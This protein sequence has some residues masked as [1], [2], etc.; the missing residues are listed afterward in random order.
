MVSVGDH[1][2]CNDPATE[3]DFYLRLL[4]LGTAAEPEPLLEQAL[5][6]IVAASAAHT[7]YIEL[8]DFD[9]RGDEAPRYWRA[10]GCTDEDVASI[11]ASISRG[12]IARTLAEGR[13]IATPSALADPHFRG[14]Q[15]VLRHGI[16]AVLCAPIG[17]PPP[18][19]GRAPTNAAR[20]GRLPRGAVAGQ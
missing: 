9:D 11:R 10:H 8:R 19:A 18:S 13:T 2:V 15:S 12:I 17:Q 7:A 4:D 20:A 14:Q 6:T 16:H 1:G 5:A 3:R